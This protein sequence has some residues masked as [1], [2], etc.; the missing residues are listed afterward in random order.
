[1]NG[2][3]ARAFRRKDEG[4][5]TSGDLQIIARAY[6]AAIALSKMRPKPTKER[7]RRPAPPHSP[8]WPNSENQFMQSRPV[9]VDRPVRALAAKLM[10]GV[11][12]LD[13]VRNIPAHYLVRI[14][15][16]LNAP[17]HVIDRMATTA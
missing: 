8:T 12:P 17:K 3:K 16:M 1:M 15:S 5:A 10:S 2:K 6:K 9:I 11:T 13:G 14:R 4:R 7:V